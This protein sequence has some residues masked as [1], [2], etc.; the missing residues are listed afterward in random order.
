MPVTSPVRPT[1][2]LTSAPAAEAGLALEV[3]LARSGVLGERRQVQGE[4]ERVGARSQGRS[5]NGETH[6]AVI[7]DARDRG[8]P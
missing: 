5:G 3:R 4:G 7:R 8:C 1:A 6:H 2:K